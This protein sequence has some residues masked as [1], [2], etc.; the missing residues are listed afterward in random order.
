MIK[1]R[2]LKRPWTGLTAVAVLALALPACN[3]DVSDPDI[4]TPEDATDPAT[5]PDVIS[6]MVGDFQLA[7]DDYV[8]DAALFTDEFLLAGTFPTRQ[9]MN[10]R[11]MLV[12]NVTINTDLWEKQHVSRFSADQVVDVL[13]GDVSEVD[14]DV[15]S[16]GLAFGRYYGAMARVMMAEM[17]CQ[18]I[19]GGGD[20]EAI[21]YESAPI[22]PDARMEQALAL[23]Q[24]A[25]SSATAAGEQS[26]AV[27]AAMG[28][29]RTNMWLGNYAAAAAAAS[30]VSPSFTFY[31][32]YSSN[33]PAQYN[34]VY[35]LT[36]GDT[37]VIRYSVGDGLLPSRNFE[38][39]PYYDEWVALG[40]V[41]PEP[42]G[43]F[44]AFDRSVPV[45]LQT[46]YGASVP[47]PSAS[48]QAAPILISSGFEADII[49]AEVMYRNG[50]MAGASALIN[51]RITDPAANPH[52]KAFSPVAFTGDFATD[53]AE[54]GRAYLAGMWLTG[55]RLH[56]M[57]RVYRN[58]GVDLF[59][60]LTDGSDTAFPVPQQE[61]DNNPD[62][63]QS[64]PSGPPW[65]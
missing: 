51:S 42:G 32:E 27:A 12:Q 49:Q 37:E 54:I 19:L 47:P 11:Q 64:C 18:S 29:A 24:Q 59:P 15:V 17:F 30:Q 28:Q 3:L 20:P 39:F 56:F 58:D 14:P 4:V 5:L 61:L 62:I 65:S 53:I 7:F 48:G 8:R 22:G 6:G 10:Q 60:P 34:E 57:R 45:R 41:N 55:Y 31:S 21:N 38:V 23:F 1:L 13:S 26:L 33:V 63:S 9:E 35:T 25:E 50:D 46:I 36:Y 2:W 52:G 43:S 16:R 40:L 44:L